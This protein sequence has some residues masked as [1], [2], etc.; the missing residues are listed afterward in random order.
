M[1]PGIS[2]DEWRKEQARNEKALKARDDEIEALKA[3][4]TSEI[5]WAKWYSDRAT[6]LRASLEKSNAL[7]CALQYA[8][9]ID[10]DSLV[11]Q[12]KENAQ[13]LEEKP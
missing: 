8:Q 11:R 12:C 2:L 5:N 3:D 6:R 4:L 7:L 10:L 1:K 9:P 13:V